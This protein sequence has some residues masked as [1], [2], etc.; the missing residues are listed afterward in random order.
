MENR[1]IVLASKSPRRAELL[2]NIKTEFEIRVSDADESKIPKDLHPKMYVQ[3][4][5]VL[6]STSVAPLCSKNSLVIGADTVVVYNDEIIGKPKD[7]EDAVRILSMLSGR[8][9]C[10]YTG[11]SV[12]D[13]KSGHTVSGYE[14]TEVRFK[15]LTIDEIESYTDVEPPYDKAGAYGIQGRASLFAESIEGDFFNVVGLPLCALNN[16][17]I[18]EFEFSL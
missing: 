16:L 1:K 2:K 3:E 9:H 18:K 8:T 17:L 14:K 6:K 10:V 12:T 15:N 13:A 7:R 11:F 5:A 4:L